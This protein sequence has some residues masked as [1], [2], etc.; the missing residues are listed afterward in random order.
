MI[1]RKG[2]VYK[3]DTPATTLLIRAEGCAEYLYYGKRLSVPGFGYDFLSCVG[4]DGEPA[5]EL[6][7]S[8]G[9]ADSRLFSVSC[10]FADG[11]FSPRFSFLRAKLTEKPSLAPLPSSYCDSA[12]KNAGQTLVLEFSDEPSKLRLFLYYTV[13]DDSDVIA[14]SSR[15]FNGGKRE[16]R[17]KKLASLQ[18]DVYGGGYSFVSF[19]EGRDG[20]YAK[21]CAPVTDGVA[22]NESRFGDASPFA[23]PFAMLEKEGSVYAFNLVYSGGYKE[24]AEANAFRTRVL[25]GVNDFMLD[26]ALL[27]GESFSSPEAVMAFATDED[28]VSLAMHDFVLRHIVR[29]RWKGKER[30]VVFEGAAGESG[31]IQA[32]AEAE[33]AARLGAEVYVGNEIFPAEHFGNVEK[34]AAAGDFAEAVRRAGLKFGLRVNPE[35]ISENGDLYKKHPEYAVKL[36]N[37]TPFRG[38]ERLFLNFADPRVQ[39]Y[40][41]RALSSL[42]SETKASYVRWETGGRMTDGF[43]R[44]VPAGEYFLRYTEGL[45][46]VAGRIAEKFPGVLFERASDGGG[47]YDLGLLCYFS[48]LAGEESDAGKGLFLR[49]GVSFGYP[50]SVLSSR[51]RFGPASRNFSSG[52]ELLFPA[53]FGPLSFGTELAALSE[54]QAEGIKRRIAFY[55]KYRR[56]LQYGKTYRLGNAFSGD[57]FEAR[58]MLAVSENR[59]SA[60]GIV[61]AEKGR[62]EELRICLKGLDEGAVYTVSVFGGGGENDCGRRENFTASGELLNAGLIPLKIFP[63]GSFPRG[64]TLFAGLMI[65]KAKKNKGS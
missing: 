19:R 65:E 20:E 49:S 56:L 24:T 15:L 54:E 63:E 52:G 5:L 61:W 60:L 22:V 32:L 23:N 35:S 55:K 8:F 28:G 9:G 64:G 30:P 7:S 53:A 62:G 16:V 39:K 21:V 13:F 46:A 58:G 27:P 44:D 59:A 51:L 11:S 10:T 43:C 37:R 45:Y 4:A 36:P 47:K 31:R 57:R 41:V 26:K 3:L 40:A 12:E 50:Q 34:G 6:V 14:V 1:K 38:R 18:L 2:N 17:I 29:G 33:Q 42:L 25:V 48:Q